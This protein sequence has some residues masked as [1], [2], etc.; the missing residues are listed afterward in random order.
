VKADPGGLLEAL[1]ARCGIVCAV[2][3]GGK[4]STLYRLALA[5]RELG[6]ARIALTTTVMTAPPPASLAAE[7]LLA[8]PEELCRQ[9]PLL[10]ERHPLLAYAQPSPKPGRLGGVAPDLVASLHVAGTFSV[11]LVK[12][13]GARMRLIKAPAP[14]EPVLPP[15]VAT[16]LPVV[17]ARAFGRALDET[18]AHRL[19]RVAATTGAAPGER[20]GPGHVARLLASGQGGLRHAGEALVVPVINM[21]DDRERLG[22]ARRAAQEALALTQRF[23]R[24]V[25]AAMTAPEPIVEVVAR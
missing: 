22:L 2:G 23:D 18:I 24:V 5:H 4:K 19:E 25:L 16:L 17:S 1:G 7:R 8:C 12:A 13:D 9:L 11:T 20:I 21:V 10:A 15:D 3:A 6:T 14:D